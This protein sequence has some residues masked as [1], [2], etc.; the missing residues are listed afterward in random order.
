MSQTVIQSMNGNVVNRPNGLRVLGITSKE[1]VGVPVLNV[2]MPTKLPA[3]LA[4]VL[5]TSR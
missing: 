1:I 3:T 5:I 2:S 4:V